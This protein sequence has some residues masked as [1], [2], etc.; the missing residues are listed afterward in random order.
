MQ[1]NLKDI[2]LKRGLTQKQV[3][4]LLG[5]KCED[6]LSHWERGTAMPSVKNLMKLGRVYKVKVEQ[7]LF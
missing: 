5:L 1:N 6:R 4:D 7:L 3:A 2:R